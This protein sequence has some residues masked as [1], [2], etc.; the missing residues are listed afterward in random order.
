MLSS[1][2]AVS[3]VFNANGAASLLA[4][5]NAPGLTETITQR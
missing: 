3:D 4:W 1:A 5:G 2:A